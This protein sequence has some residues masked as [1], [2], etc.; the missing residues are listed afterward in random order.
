MARALGRMLVA[1]AVTALAFVAWLVAP[2]F[3]GRPSVPKPVDFELADKPLQVPPRVL[4]SGSGAHRLSL[5]HATRAAARVGRNPMLLRS[6][7]LE[8]PTRFNIV[9]MRWRGA[10][11]AVLFMRVKQAGGGW[12]G[13]VRVG[14]DS[15]DGPD[16]RSTE[17]KP[18]W[19]TSAPVWAGEADHVQYEMAAPRS[20][21]SIRLHFVKSKGEPTALDK[22]RSSLHRTVSAALGTV[23]RLFGA[24][25]A[26]D[27]ISQPAIVSRDA[28]GASA[29]PPRVTPAYGQVKL[30]FIHHTVTASN[31]GPGDS[32]AMVLGICRYHRNSN[33]WNDIGYNFLVDKYGTIFEGRA[34]GTDQAVVGA[35]AQGYNNQST[36]IANL[37]TFSTVGQTTAGLDALARLLS[38]KLAVHGVPPTGTVTVTSQGGA[39]NRYSAGSPV[40]VQR[41]SGHRVVDRTACPG[42]GLYAQLPQLRS[43][44]SRDT[45]IATSLS[46][47]SS[48][49]DVSFG[50]RIRLSGSLAGSDGAPLSNRPV[51]V[52]FL[53][54]TGTLVRATTDA[55][56][57]FS[58][59]LLLAYNRLLF[60]S[61]G[62]DSGFRPIQSSVV[63][64]GVRPRVTAALVGSASVQRGRVVAFTGRVQPRKRRILLLVDRQGRDGAYR[65]I[66]RKPIRVLRSGGVRAR[67]RFRKP[68]RYRVLLGAEPDALNLRARSV[69]LTVTVL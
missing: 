62:G 14:T 64:V 20:V 43:M 19:N 50:S 16:P 7:P 11:G 69:S 41:I 39:T 54:S 29:C 25:A 30:A 12:G 49:S 42:D 38:W 26:A 1:I 59:K 37:G 47:Q 4:S 28:W 48:R 22:F 35:Q 46:L 15:D 32:A 63:N 36:G 65:R 44:V 18:G 67:Y 21:R 57:R 53:G 45:R 5:S 60:A 40:Q 61:F 8:T 9:G 56:G 27:Q 6:R 23:T 24:S 52:S 13:W 68:G 2:A 3:S 55:R 31:Y 33:G 58:A 34:G 51:R 10:R 17:G 66:A